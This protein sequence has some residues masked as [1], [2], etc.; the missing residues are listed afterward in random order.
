M[1]EQELRGERTLL[2]DEVTL[3]Y[4]VHRQDERLQFTLKNDV[5]SAW[6]L[7]LTTM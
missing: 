3:V 7:E 5:A 4:G 6:S 2:P 1:E